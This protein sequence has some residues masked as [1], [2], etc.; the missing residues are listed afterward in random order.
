MKKNEIE[1]LKKLLIEKFKNVQIKN[2]KGAN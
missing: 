2:E 1:K